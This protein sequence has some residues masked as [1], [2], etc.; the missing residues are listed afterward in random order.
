MGVDAGKLAGLMLPLDQIQT[1][2]LAGIVLFVGYG[3]RRVLPFLATYNIPAPVVGGL[4]IAV[5][6]TTAARNGWMTLFEFNDRR[7]SRR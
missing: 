2:A 3:I 4:L 6:I 5:V 7:C 1:V